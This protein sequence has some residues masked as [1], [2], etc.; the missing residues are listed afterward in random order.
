MLEE[1]S[2]RIVGG[3]RYTS[4]AAGKTLKNVDLTILED[5]AND[6]K[7]IGNAASGARDSQ[8]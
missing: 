5:E 3:L 6:V 7:I 2:W 1:T 4:N 8:L